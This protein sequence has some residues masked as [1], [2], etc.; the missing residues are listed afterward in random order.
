MTEKPAWE[1]QPG[2]QMDDDTALEV[3]KI[4]CAL[5]ALSVYTTLVL[6]QED[7]SE[8]LEQVVQSGLEAV[9]KVFKV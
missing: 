7:N 2:I 3:S 5:K 1:L 4:A 9:N 8:E 6:E